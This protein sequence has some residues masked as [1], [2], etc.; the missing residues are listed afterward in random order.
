MAT[1]EALNGVPEDQH[2]ANLVVLALLVGLFMLLFGLLRLGFL[3]RFISN[4]VLTGFL[5]GLGVLTILSQVGDLTGYYS[6][7][8]QKVVQ[9]VDTFLHWSQISVITLLVGLAT[10]HR[11]LAH[12]HCGALPPGPAG[13]SPG[14]RTGQ[15]G[16]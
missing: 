9:T 7:A 11:G 2:L 3:I 8:E 4:A 6:D 16:W 5:S 12:L 10:G 1:L 14:R 15:S 13:L